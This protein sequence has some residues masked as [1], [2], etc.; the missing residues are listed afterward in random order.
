MIKG[1]CQSGRKAVPRDSKSDLP[2]QVCITNDRL[3]DLSD[4]C[5]DNSDEGLALCEGRNQDDDET[6]FRD[7]F[8]E[9]SDKFFSNDPNNQESNWILGSGDQLLKAKS[10]PFDHTLLTDK[11]HY[12]RLKMDGGAQSLVMASLVSKYLQ[13]PLEAND[14]CRIRFYLHFT[15]D[16]GLQDMKFVLGLR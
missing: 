7:T 9:E 15:K 1:D 2:L 10:P 3:C 14:T 8:E 5:G 11:G 12:M 13:P 4:D 16:A 6:Y